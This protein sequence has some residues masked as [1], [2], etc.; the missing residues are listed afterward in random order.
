M[1]KALTILA[2]CGA[3]ACVGVIVLHHC[4]RIT[5]TIA[6]NDPPAESVTVYRGAK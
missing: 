3:I 1:V 2:L 6:Y 4:K 5:I